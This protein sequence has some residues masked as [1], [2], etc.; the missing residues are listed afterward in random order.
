MRVLHIISGDLWAGA[1]SMAYHLISGLGKHRQ[2]K[3]SAVLF[4]DGQLSGEIRELGVPVFIVNENEEHSFNII[5]YMVK[6]IKDSPP[7]IIHSH[8]LKENLLAYISTMLCDNSIALINT[9]HGM[10][11]PIDRKLQFI[12]RYLLS[13]CNMYVLKNKYKYIVA[14]S[15]DMRNKLVSN[16]KVPPDKIR[17]IHNGTETDFPVHLP[18]HRKDLFVIGS[19]GRFFPVKDYRLMVEIA[20]EINKTGSATRFELAGDG[21]ERGLILGLIRKYH[22]EEK[23]ILRGY[24]E[25]MA[26]FYRGID[27]YIN[28]S[29]HEG[30]PMGVLEA[31]AHGIPV[32]VPDTGGMSEII[33]N[34][35]EGYKINGRDPK[36][37]AEK[38]REIMNNKPMYDRMAGESR[39]RIVKNFSYERMADEYYNIYRDS[40]VGVN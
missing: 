27:L 38:C 31:M 16:E 21:P 14:V 33:T 29:L 39:E 13:R 12:K 6:H 7:D 3:V 28:T 11:E 10:P 30:L 15:S 35:V 4:N 23:F 26:E 17:V 25:N 1:E 8:G 9:Q 36:L 22:L 40:A 32:I 24:M 34:G 37:F 19:A 5:K 20:M 2:V 18:H